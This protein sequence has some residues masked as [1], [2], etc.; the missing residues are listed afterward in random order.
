VAAAPRR[1]AVVQ[2][3]LGGGTVDA[4]ACAARA[5]HI[6]LV[7]SVSPMSVAEHAVTLIKRV[8]RGHVELRSGAVGTALTSQRASSHNYVGLD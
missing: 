6:D 5:I 1:T 8:D 7:E 4:A 3:E 2:I